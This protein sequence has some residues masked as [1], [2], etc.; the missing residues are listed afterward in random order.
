LSHRSRTSGNRVVLYLSDENYLS[1]IA[2]LT[3]AGE[4]RPPF[5]VISKFYNDLTEAWRMRRASQEPRN[6]RPDTLSPTP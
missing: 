4:D 1:V 2:A 6:D 5:G 3:P